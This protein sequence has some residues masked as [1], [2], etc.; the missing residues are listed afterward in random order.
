MLFY[1]SV[2]NLKEPTLT[3][4]MENLH[5]N[6]IQKPKI[7][8]HTKNNTLELFDDDI[9]IKRYRISL[10]HADFELIAK[11]KKYVTTPHGVFSICDIMNNS[12]YN[13]VYKLD[14]PDSS[15][16]FKAAK[17]GLLNETQVREMLK[18]KNYNCITKI[19]HKIFGPDLTIHGFGKMNVI[20]KNLPFIFN[21]TNGSIALSNEDLDEL[22]PYL[23]LGTKITVTE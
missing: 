7:I 1:G 10:G 20:F 4:T 23:T 9:L 2:L 16:I 18:N 15:T 12:N 14:Y 5:I 17:L 19:N 21:W 11:S 3:E 13:K 6:Y 8:V 22:E